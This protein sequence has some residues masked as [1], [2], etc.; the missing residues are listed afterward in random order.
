MSDEENSRELAPDNRSEPI[1]MPSRKELILF[2]CFGLIPIVVIYLFAS[3]A[4]D[5]KKGAA[6]EQERRLLIAECMK[7]LDDREACRTLIDEP[8]IEC[9]K[10]RAKP[11]GTIEDRLDLQQCITKRDDDKFRV[12]SSDEGA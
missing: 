4:I 12:E 2:A 7:Q 9:Y 3:Q 10:A 1:S 8:L 5:D 6:F 11:D